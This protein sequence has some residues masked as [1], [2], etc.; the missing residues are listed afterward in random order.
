MLNTFWCIM[1]TKYKSGFFFQ[2]LAM[3]QKT[4]VYVLNFHTVIL[5]CVFK[6]RVPACETL[7]LWSV[8]I[9]HTFFSSKT[10]QYTILRQHHY[11]LP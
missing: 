3:S 9:I 4:K 8:T 2:M 7:V 11:P 10:L 1:E 6:Q 5:K